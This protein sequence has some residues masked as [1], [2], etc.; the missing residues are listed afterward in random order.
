MWKITGP[1]IIALDRRT[2]TVSPEINY[3]YI[4][5]YIMW[6]CSRSHPRMMQTTTTD[7]SMHEISYR[8]R[9]PSAMQRQPIRGYTQFK[10]TFMWSTQQHT[11]LLPKVITRHGLSIISVVFFWN[12]QQQ[13]PHMQA[14]R[15][16]QLRMCRAGIDVVSPLVIGERTKR[17]SSFSRVTGHGH[18]RSPRPA[19]A[20]VWTSHQ[21]SSRYPSNPRRHDF[22]NANLIDYK[23]Q[24]RMI[25]H[26]TC[27]MTFN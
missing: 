23:R 27:Q 16:H 6:G 24:L 17:A 13:E 21:S 2:A 5:P 25:Q 19:R 1:L 7:G 15:R 10:I 12:Q 8:F 18:H 9:C 26:E 11:M 22:L 3:I 14:E 20:I 4:H